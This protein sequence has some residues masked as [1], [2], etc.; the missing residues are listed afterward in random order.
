MLTLA[1]GDQSWTIIFSGLI[2]ACIGALI[3]QVA[4][5]LMTHGRERRQ[6]LREAYSSFGAG[7]YRFLDVKTDNINLMIQDR[8]LEQ[9]AED[10]SPE[11]KADVKKWIEDWNRNQESMR[12][13]EYALSE[14]RCMLRMLLG[15]N[16]HM[17]REV[18]DF[19][20]RMLRLKYRTFRNSCKVIPRLVED[21]RQHPSQV[22]NMR[23][24]LEVWLDERAAQIE[25]MDIIHR[26]C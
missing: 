22:F 8:R 24:D 23:L 1:G 19:F 16:K 7:C 20:E 12:Q 15:G 10:T 18:N 25:N 3:G 14:S 21:G 13:V 5:H 6:K 4:G 11:H 17:L 2:G 9:L 26:C